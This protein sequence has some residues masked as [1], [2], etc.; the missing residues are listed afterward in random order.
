M[1]LNIVLYH[2]VLAGSARVPEAETHSSRTS[3][4]TPPHYITARQ[5]RPDRRRPYHTTPHHRTSRQA[6]PTPLLSKSPSEPNLAQ[7]L[8]SRPRGGFEGRLVGVLCL[9]GTRYWLDTRQRGVQRM[10]GTGGATI[11]TLIPSSLLCGFHPPITIHAAQD[12][13]RDRQHRTEPN[14]TE[15][16]QTQPKREQERAE[17]A[18][19]AERA[20]ER[21]ERAERKQRER[22]QRERAE[23]EQRESRARAE[24]G[25]ERAEKGC[26]TGL[27]R[28]HHRVTLA[29]ACH[30][31][32][33]LPRR[34]HDDRR[35]K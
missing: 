12:I 1:L 7:S 25:T 31:P 32:H 33:R 10:A 17:R 4:A 18:E 6:P 22:E 34:L 20:R 29:G 13:G 2:I 23:R 28:R 35:N 26:E 15:P 8:L 24:R 30:G 3:Y 27:H 5:T 19:G 16:N 21:R 11:R 9:G 14:Q